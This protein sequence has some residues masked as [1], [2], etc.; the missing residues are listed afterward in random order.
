MLCPLGVRRPRQQ[1]PP[2]G[3]SC[4]RFLWIGLV[5]R[6]DFPAHLQHRFLVL[7]LL[8]HGIGRQQR[9]AAIEDLPLPPLQRPVLR[10]LPRDLGRGEPDRL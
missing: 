9:L 6:Q 7:L 5:E 4:N 1:R 10:V 2:E 8:G 3:L